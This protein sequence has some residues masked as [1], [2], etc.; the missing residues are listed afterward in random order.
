MATPEAQAC[1]LLFEVLKGKVI[2]LDALLPTDWQ[3]RVATRTSRHGNLFKSLGLL[4]MSE[5]DELSAIGFGSPFTCM[6][7]GVN[8]CSS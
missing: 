4:R 7:A 2:G 3:E 5:I 8:A 1:M 6:Q